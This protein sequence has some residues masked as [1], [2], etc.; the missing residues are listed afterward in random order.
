MLFD[1]RGRQLEGEREL[2][3]GGRFQAYGELPEVVLALVLEQGGELPHPEQY[4]VVELDPTHGRVLRLA[5]WRTVEV[6]VSDAGDGLAR[7]AIRLRAAS[8]EPEFAALGKWHTLRE[9]TPEPG[10]RR[11]GG[12]LAHGRY[13]ISAHGVLIETVETE[14]EVGA[15][16][17]DPIL[18]EIAPRAAPR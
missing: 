5:P 12:V 10:A 9:L 1:A 13:R 4:A 15:D 14:L 8:T 17:P 16:G 2:D 3:A 18:M 11:F 7:G 6:R